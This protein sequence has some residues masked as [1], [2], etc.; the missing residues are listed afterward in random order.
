MR[1]TAVLVVFLF[2][3]TGLFAKE[4]FLSVTGKAGGFF[5]DARIFNPSYTKDITVNAQY[6]PAGNGDNASAPVVPLVIPKRTMKL[7]DDAVVSMF[8]RT[9]LVTLGGIR[10]V[11][12]DDF[13]ATQRVYADRR[14]SYQKGTLGQFVAGQELSRGLKKGVILQLKSGLASLGSFR[15]NWGGVNPNTSVANVSFK[16]Y[17]RNNVLAGTNNLT[18]QPYGVFSPVNIVNFFGA[19]NADLTDAWISFES[20][21]PVFLYGSVVDNGADDQTFV[22][23]VEDT[24]VAP[25]PPVV[26]T[27][28]ISATGSGFNVSGPAL[29]PRDQVRFVATNTSGQTHG[30]QF[31]DPDGNPLVTLD[32]IGAAS[33]E[34]TI[35]LPDKNGN[36]PYICTR[37]TCSTHGVMNGELRVQ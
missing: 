32:P 1:R 26:K 3:A 6:L 34:I 30:F 31:F 25:P 35:T 22:A 11:S 20:D 10:L 15:T 27:V 9:E 36:Y 12:D 28:T 21:Q 4:V 14:D 17:D 13:V 19:Q 24:G 2:F 23:A 33:S 8:G 16:L 5:S 37:P 29:A 7:Y 18:F